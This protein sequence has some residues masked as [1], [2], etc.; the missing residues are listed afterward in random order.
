MKK[1]INEQYKDDLN[2]PLS[3][4]K[5]ESKGVRKRIEGFIKKN[6][7]PKIIEIEEINSEM[8]FDWEELLEKLLNSSATVDDEVIEYIAEIA[9]HH[10]I[11]NSSFKQINET[12]NKI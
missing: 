9:A 6:M 8:N 4:S 5:C 11:I 2:N 12:I 1:D 10:R 3:I 7:M